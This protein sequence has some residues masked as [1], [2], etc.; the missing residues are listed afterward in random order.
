MLSLSPSSSLPPPAPVCSTPNTSTNGLFWSIVS[1]RGTRRAVLEDSFA[2]VPF[3]SS[4]P[5]ASLFALFD[6]H[7]GASVAQYASKRLLEF[8]EEEMRN[9]GDVMNALERAF[10]GTDEEVLGDAKARGCGT[11]ATVVVLKGQDVWI[12]WVGD[13]GVV[14]W[15]EEDGMRRLVE[16]HRPG[17]REE[18]ER[19]EKAGGW[20]VKGGR[21]NGVLA[22]SRA[23]GDGELKDLVIAR[24]E[25]REEKLKG[26]RLIM[27]TDGLWD[28]VNDEEVGDMEA[29]DLV[30]LAVERG[31]RDDVTVLTIDLDKYMEIWEG[32]DDEEQIEV[33]RRMELESGNNSNVKKPHVEDDVTVEKVTPIASDLHTS[34]A[35]S[36]TSWP[37]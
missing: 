27:A 5:P 28:W 30:E 6:G 7:G 15:N 37:W 22:V 34:R 21:V 20:V 12:G 29:K 3:T 35:S 13:S 10:L 36:G 18:M 25:V 19:I 16:D 11:T 33:I 26:G 4:K 31:G 2:I 8:V 1:R 14:V 23:L 32:R 9:C 17:R 24:P